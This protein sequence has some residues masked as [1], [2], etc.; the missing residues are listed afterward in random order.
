MKARPSLIVVAAVVGAALAAA[1]TL[2]P[3]RQ[4]EISGSW[5][6]VASAPQRR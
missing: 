3:V 5:Q 4:P 6:P 2:R 1:Y